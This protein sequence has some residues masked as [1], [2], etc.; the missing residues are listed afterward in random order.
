MHVHIWRDDIAPRES[1]WCVTAQEYDLGV[2]VGSG[3]TPLRAIE[4]LLWR[5]DIENVG[6]EQY[7]IIW[8]N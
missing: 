8:E 1:R 6:P 4:D 2:P 3:A 7:T 5:L